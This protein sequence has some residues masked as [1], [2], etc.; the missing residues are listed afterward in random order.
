MPRVD[1]KPELALRREL[2]SRGLRFRLH[3]PL[4]GR[5]DIALTRARIAIFVDGC[6]WH[7]CPEHFTAPKNNR[8]WWKAK[9][10][11]NVAR[12]RRSDASLEALGWAVVHVWEH[13]VIS[14]AAGRIELMW[15]S[16][17]G[18]QRV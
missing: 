5:P 3:A 11:A 10:D 13:E 14:V 15:R 7:V 16:R 4:P 8:D 17:R 18:S 1:T 2:H 6:F 9:L 12:D